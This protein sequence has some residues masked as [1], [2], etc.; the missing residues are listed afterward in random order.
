[1]VLLLVVMVSFLISSGGRPQ[2]RPD[3]PNL[4]VINYDKEER[5]IPT[6][7]KTVGE[8]ISRLEIPL[9]EGDVVEPSQ[10]TEIVG[11]NF[12]IN[13]YRAVPVTIV[14]GE[15]KTF[16]YSAASTS[17]SIVK[18][19]GITVYPEDNLELLPTENFLTESSI[20]ERVVIRRATPVTLNVYGTPAVVRTHAK[21]V[22]DLVQERGIKL[23]KDDTVLPSLDQPITANA[24]I[25]LVRNGIQLQ[26]IEEAVAMPVEEVQ[27]ASLTFGA[28]AVRQ[29]GAPGK[30]LVTYQLTLQNGQETGRKLI[31][32]VVTQEPVKQ[33]VA[34][35]KAFSPSA[36]KTAAMAAA[37]IKPSDYPYA[38]YIITKESRWNH[39]A[40]N[41]SSG[42]YGLCQ[43]YPGTKMANTAQNGGPDWQT[44]PIT[45]LRWCNWYA[46]NGSR[47]FKGWAEAYNYWIANK[48]W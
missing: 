33:I 42:A 21:T 47:N 9:H 34:K 5:T 40:R 12:R 7:A 24:Q 16:T 37:G 23:E 4:V 2:L 19:A 32:E 10:D 20:G 39:L 8:L 41:A 29:Q 15:Q 43:S 36:D 3:D 31:Q 13:V 11:D 38:D 14:D 27:D 1:M 35:G 25:F 17:R 26:T 22:G 46:Y 45:Q 48:H 44:N 30:K 28:S 18:Q 6:D